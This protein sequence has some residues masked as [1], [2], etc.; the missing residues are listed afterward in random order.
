MQGARST[1]TEK[2]SEASFSEGSPSGDAGAP[3]QIDRRGRANEVLAYAKTSFGEGSHR[4]SRCEVKRPEPTPRNTADDPPQEFFNSLLTLA[5]RER[6][7]KPGEGGLPQAQEERIHTPS[8]AGGRPGWGCGA[9]ASSAAA[10]GP[11]R[12]VAY[13][14]KKKPCRAAAAKRNLAPDSI[15]FHPGD[16]AF[17]PLLQVRYTLPSQTPSFKP[18]AGRSAA[19]HATIRSTSRARGSSGALSVAPQGLRGGGRR[20]PQGNPPPA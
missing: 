16:I 8:P 17:K 20:Q 15:S 7:A 6:V 4:R 3:S 2:T 5:H 9:A 12:P 10:T 19:R 1:A 14:R 13:Y 11:R 18:N